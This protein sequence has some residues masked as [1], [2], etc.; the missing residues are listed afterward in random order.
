[1]KT[2]CWLYT[3][4]ITGYA[5]ALPAQHTG[6]SEM[7]WKR[8]IPDADE[9][10]GNLWNTKVVDEAENRGGKRAVPDADEAVG[11]LWNS[12]VADQVED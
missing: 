8:A 9:A 4:A 10:V 3:L 7:S 1:M 5:L 2:T 12:A 11:N 6:H